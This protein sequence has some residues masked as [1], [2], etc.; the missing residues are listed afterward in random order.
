MICFGIMANLVEASHETAAFKVCRSERHI[1][2][3]DCFPLD[4]LICIL[5]LTWLLKMLHADG[6]RPHAR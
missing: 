5:E 2:N 1:G 6:Q 3:L 4:A